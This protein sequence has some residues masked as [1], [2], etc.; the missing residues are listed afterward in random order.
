MSESTAPDVAGEVLH[1]YAEY[2]ARDNVR[3]GPHGDSDA[4]H[5]SIAVAGACELARDLSA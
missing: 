4:R 5:F 2:L 1:R 3:A